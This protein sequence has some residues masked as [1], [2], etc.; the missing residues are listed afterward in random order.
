MDRLRIVDLRVYKAIGVVGCLATAFLVGA[1]R[2]LAAVVPAVI[3][4]LA[5]KLHNSA[6]ERSSV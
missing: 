3:V 5:I 1:G 2:V 6:E 4:F